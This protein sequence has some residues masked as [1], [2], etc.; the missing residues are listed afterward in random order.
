ME[1]QSILTSKSYKRAETNLKDKLK[2]AFLKHQP[3]Y[4]VPGFNLHRNFSV[5]DS[6]LE[7][8]IEQY[9]E[10]PYYCDLSKPLLPPSKLPRSVLNEEDPALEL[11]SFKNQV[12]ND[13]ERMKCYF[14]KHEKELGLTH[15]KDVKWNRTK[16][17]LNAKVP[18]YIVDL[19]QT[20]GKDP[21]P[22]FEGVY[23]WYYTGGTIDYVQL[24][25]LNILIFPFMGELVTAPINNVEE[26][27]WKPLLQKAA[28]CELDGSLYEL[29]HYVSDDKCI[30]LG[31]YKWN[32]NF[33]I[34]SERDYKCN[35][36]EIHTQTSKVPY[37]SAD[38]NPINRNQYCSLNVERC[39]TLWD[40]TKMKPINSKTISQTTVLDDSWGCIKFQ[41]ID[42]NVLLFV[43]RCCLHYLDTRV[44]YDQPALTMCPKFYLERCEDISLD[45]ASRNNFCRYIGTYHSI[46]MC[47]YRSP[48]QC[49]QQK[50]THQFKG[51]PLMGYTADR[52]DKEF[53]VLSSQI[54]GESTIL[55]NT[56]TSSETS[57][58]FNFPY[59]PPDI[60][61]TLNESQMQ[62]MCLN[63]YLKD[64]FELS[65]TGS[66][67]IK[68]DSQNI[69]LFLQNS[70]GDIY[71]QCITHD[72]QLDKYSPI[73][74][75]SFCIMNAWEEAMSE[76][77]NSIVPL[78]VSSKTN[79]QHLLESFSNKKLRLK[80]NKHNSDDC[81]EPSWKQSLE[82]LSTYMDILAP[83]LLAMW[84][85]CEDVPLPLTMPSHQKVLSWLESADTKAPVLSQEEIENISLPINSQELISVSQEID[86]TFLDDSNALQ[87]LLPKVKT[88]RSRKKEN[89]H[90]RKK[91]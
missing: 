46:L 51:P 63:P 64:R 73:N 26:F 50:W 85:I 29:K 58:S 16:D 56:W 82:K 23:N 4:L 70:I 8:I 28:K 31:R 34:L 68:S 52:E 13:I 3:H 10:Y 44:P 49:V 76:Q 14:S 45:I 60:R 6:D 53:I 80:Y 47:D 78:T 19:A 77:M 7:N 1:D 67:L 43:D 27:L 75:K 89:T 54:A 2:P 18:K 30:I 41:S 40:V 66:S 25:N 5:D 24:H 38:L 17:V 88:V 39:V 15:K 86:I 33:Y 32:C 81:F 9:Q 74:G 91:T 12:N 84:D 57:H 11:V 62:G 69:F 42:P 79:I 20:M 83:E 61:E 90:K 37:I 48:K 55:I 72:N 65:N 36:T 21:D 87:G 22:Y 71:Y 59:I 35:L